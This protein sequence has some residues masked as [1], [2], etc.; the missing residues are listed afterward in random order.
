M[1][2]AKL[3]DDL[4][5]RVRAALDEAEE[6][7]REIQHPPPMPLFWRRRKILYSVYY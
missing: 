6:K 2:A 5:G 4:T 3:V 1:D 7:A